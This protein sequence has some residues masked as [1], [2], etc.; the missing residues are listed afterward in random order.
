V[1]TLK[2]SLDAGGHG[3][4]EMPSGTGKRGMAEIYLNSDLTEISVTYKVIK[5]QIALLM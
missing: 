4:L 1:V 3:V 5:L 2:L